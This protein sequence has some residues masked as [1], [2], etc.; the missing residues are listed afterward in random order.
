MFPLA[1]P[2]TRA[3]SCPP[4]LCVLSQP[5]C[6]LPTTPALGSPSPLAPH[7]RGA[8]SLQVYGLRMF[9]FSTLYRSIVSLVRLL[10]G[11][12]AIYHEMAT[13]RRAPSPD[14]RQLY[15]PCPWP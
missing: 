1:L 6:P 4:N 14:R 5:V 3:P 8:A 7:P 11:D 9:V 12:D 2:T 10:M 13:S 15:D